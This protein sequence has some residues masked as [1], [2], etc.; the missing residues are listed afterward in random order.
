MPSEVLELRCCQHSLR[1]LHAECDT[2]DASLSRSAAANRLAPSGEIATGILALNADF[3]GLRI[4]ID[5]DVAFEMQCFVL[6]RLFGHSAQV[7]CAS[8]VPLIDR[9]ARD[10]GQKSLTAGAP[11]L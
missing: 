5:P 4:A 1:R 9:T 6:L 2:C 8:A 7:G 11:Y 3:D 10:A